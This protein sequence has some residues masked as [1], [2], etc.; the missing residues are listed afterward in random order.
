PSPT[1]NP[2]TCPTGTP[3]TPSVEI[4]ATLSP[5]PSPDLP[6]GGPGVLAV[7]ADGDSINVAHR[8]EFLDSNKRHALAVWYRRLNR[9]QEHWVYLGFVEYLP[10]ETTVE[11]PWS[12]LDQSRYLLASRVWVDGDGWYLDPV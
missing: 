11:V 1:F 2:A 4:T 7:A 12:P 6:P 10:G 5:T 9:Q 3:Y 8:G